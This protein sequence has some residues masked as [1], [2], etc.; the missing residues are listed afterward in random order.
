MARNLR[1]IRDHDRAK[2]FGVQQV[3]TEDDL[4]TTTVREDA[5]IDLLTATSTESA[6][7]F[8]GHGANSR[9]D[10]NAGYF[11]AALNATGGG[12]G[13]AGDN[14]TGTFRFIVYDDSEDEVPVVGPTYTATDLFD[15]ESDNRTERPVLPLLVPGAGKDKS[16]AVQFKADSNSDGVVIDGAQ[17]NDDVLIP[18]TQVLQ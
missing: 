15:A 17:S 18:H 1:P 16:I 4:S 12:T 9:D 3:W 10:A 11:Y 6:K 8:M 2:S 13:T 7:Y 14:L 5:Y